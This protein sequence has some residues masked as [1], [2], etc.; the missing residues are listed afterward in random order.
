[1]SLFFPILF[2]SIPDDDIVGIVNRLRLRDQKALEEIFD[3]YG[4]L[5]YSMIFRIVRDAAVA[6]DLTQ[7]S[8]LRMW[9]RIRTFDAQKVKFAP[10]FLT[11]ARNRALEYNRSAKQDEVVRS[12]ECTASEHPN[13][14]SSMSDEI[15]HS[16]KGEKLRAVFEGLEAGQRQAL[17]LTFFEA[18]HQSEIATRLNQPVETVRTWLRTALETLRF[19]INHDL[20]AGDFHEDPYELFVLG[21]ADAESAA[22]IRTRLDQG[23][24]ETVKAIEH[25]RELAIGLAFTAPFVEPPARLRQRILVTFEA[26]PGGYPKRTW[27]WISALILLGLVTFNFWQR[28]QIK[29]RELS[30]TK[31]EL[32]AASAHLAS[33]SPVMEFLNEPSTLVIGF[34]EETSAQ[35]QGKVLLNARKGAL[36]VASGFRKPMEGKIYQMWI[37]PATGSA[38]PAGLFQPGTDGKVVH[39]F[40]ESLSL[41]ETSSIAVSEEPIAGSTTPSSPFLVIAPLPK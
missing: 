5:I 32:I 41:P 22:A 13:L 18:A 3:R 34:G 27:I 30:G 23:H 19:S 40:R 37:V 12:L 33:A 36:L 6:E 31:Q 9:N 2:T 25:A 20:P 26:E 17:E 8:F 16:K 1:M 7:E 39:P 28:E 10:W 38:Q 14:F 21:T 4:R 35:P 15:F 24:P 11:I 29:G